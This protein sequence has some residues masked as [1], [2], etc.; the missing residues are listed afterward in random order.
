MGR[1]PHAKM[2]SCIMS[3]TS[4]KRQLSDNWGLGIRM[5]KGIGADVSLSSIPPLQETSGTK[6]PD[7]FCVCAQIWKQSFK[8]RERAQKSATVLRLLKRR[9]GRSSRE[10]KKRTQKPP[11]RT[12]V[13]DDLPRKSP[14]RGETRAA[15]ERVQFERNE[16]LNQ[17]KLYTLQVIGHGWK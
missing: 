8:I 13:R 4:S 3:A 7:V 2:I 16:I 15:R 17:R 5:D 12:F 6:V 14:R 1:M 11:R 9:D 10:R